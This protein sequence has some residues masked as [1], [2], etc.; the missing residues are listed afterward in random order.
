MRH[1]Y[2]GGERSHPARNGRHGAR[3]GLH[4]VEVDVADE[5]AGALVPVD[6]HVDDHLA[7][8]HAVRAHHARPPAGDDEHARLATSPCEVTG[9]GVA[10]GHGGVR[11]LEH[12]RDGP[13]DHERAAHHGHASPLER[14]AGGVQQVHDRARRARGVALARASEHAGERCRGEAV[15]VLLGSD[16]L[17]GGRLFERGGQGAKHQDAVDRGVR[18]GGGD[19]SHELALRAGGVE[20]DLTHV[21]AGGRGALEQ[22]SLAGEVVGALAH[23]NQAERRHHAARGERSRA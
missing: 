9:L 23:A 19:G 1:K 10:H 20:D 4:D 13:T 21:N 2:G 14:H 6:A 11:G 15:D 17:A 22:A 18:V 5:P 7:G 16:G 12:H 3:D 8:T